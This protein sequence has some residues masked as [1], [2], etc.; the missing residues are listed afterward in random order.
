LETR[1]R[2][3]PIHNRAFS[4]HCTLQNVMAFRDASIYT[5]GF[6]RFVIARPAAWVAAV[7]GR[8]VRPGNILRYQNCNW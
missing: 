6:F 3:R 1:G 2:A 5:A 7:W 4:Q 8:G